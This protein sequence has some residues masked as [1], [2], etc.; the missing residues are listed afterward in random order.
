MVAGGQ[1]VFAVLVAEVE[2]V[3]DADSGLKLQDVRPSGGFTGTTWI[4]RNRQGVAFRSA[5]RKMC[6][7]ARMSTMADQ[8]EISRG[9]AQ[10][11]ELR[12]IAARIGRD[13]SIVSREVN[14]HGRAGDLSGHDGRAGR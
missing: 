3:D 8:E 13:P 2:V 1:P 12:V 11:E 10:G 4:R 5:F 6:R 7:S 14:R 9:V